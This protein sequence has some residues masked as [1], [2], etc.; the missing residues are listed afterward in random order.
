ML[1]SPVIRALKQQLK[2]ELHIL[3]KA[4]FS[5]ISENNPF[6]DKVYQFHEKVNEILPALKSE[7]YDFIVDLQ[8]NAR[9]IKLRKILGKPGSSFPKLNLEKWLLV[10]FKI[11]RLPEKHIVDRYFEAV[12]ALNVRNDGKGLDFFIPENENLNPIDIHEKLAS[13]YIGFV[14]GGMHNTKMF[15]PEKVIEVINKLKL[16]VILLGGANDHKNGEIITKSIKDHLTIN[17]CG[18]YNL[19]QSASLVKQATLIITND[20]GLMHIAA[21]FRKPIISI[22]GNTI[23]EFGMYPYLPGNENSTYRAEIENL[24]CRPCSKIGFK[25]CPKRHFKCMMDQDSNRIAEQANKLITT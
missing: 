15:P 21:A 19:N 6:I 23:P 1:T 20:T 22:W 12:N 5:S 2:C 7:N 4:K 25:E 17:T 10:N 9:S 11:N 14:I 13:G 3:T 24:K 18:Q 16:P 8:K